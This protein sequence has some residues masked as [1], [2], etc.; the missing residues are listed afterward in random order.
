[1]DNTYIINEQRIQ[2]MNVDTIKPA[3]VDIRHP[4]VEKGYSV[5]NTQSI[6][7]RPQVATY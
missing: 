5:F 2:I 6:L 4:S 7:A 3:I 1:M